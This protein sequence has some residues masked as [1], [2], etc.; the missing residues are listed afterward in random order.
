MPRENKTTPR[1]I[2]S[3][4]DKNPGT[5]RKLLQK[6]KEDGLV[7]KDMGSDIYR[8]TN[9]GA[10]TV[11]ARRDDEGRERNLDVYESDGDEDPTD[12]RTQHTQHT[13]RTQ[14]TQHTQH[15]TLDS[16]VD[17]VY[18]VDDVYGVYG[19]YGSIQEDDVTLAL[20]ESSHAMPTHPACTVCSVED[21]TGSH[22][23]KQHRQM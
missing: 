14:H 4:L 5:T 22:L 13:H 9:L 17:G 15:Y 20:P 16:T 2:A 8:L 23:H 10:E 1:H 11:K 7:T 3:E 12:N 21:G 6:M 19:V 18:A